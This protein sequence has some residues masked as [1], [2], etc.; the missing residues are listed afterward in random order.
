MDEKIVGEDIVEQ[1]VT[2]K[3]RKGTKVV[4]GEGTGTFAWPVLSQS[5]TSTFGTR[6]G[7]M[8]KGI[9]IVGNHTIMAAD[10]GKVVSAGYKSDYGNYV[11]IDHMNG[12]ETMYAHMS[13]VETTAGTIVEKGEKIGIMGSTGD[14][15]GVH[16]HFE[17]HKG[18]SLENPL[19]YLN[20]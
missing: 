12:Y 10:N 8:H 11:L 7:K 17:V 1:P 19:K 4:K 20:R 5:I 15:T 13:K 3:V 16:L 2:E 9:D 18:G 14:S 6:W